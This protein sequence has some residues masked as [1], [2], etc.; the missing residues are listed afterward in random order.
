MNYVDALFFLFLVP[1]ILISG[2][3]RKHIVIKEWIIIFSS[4]LFLSTWGHR[5][6]FTFLFV[7]AMN[8]AAARAIN[9]TSKKIS[10]YVLASTITFNIGSLAYFKYYNFFSDIL[11]GTVIIHIA[12]NDVALPLAMSFYIF[13][14]ISYLVDLQAGRTRFG[15]LREYLFYLSFFPHLVAGPIVRSWQLFPQIGKC[16]NIPADV[17]IG[18]Y[19]L[20]SGLFLK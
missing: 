6:L 17:P 9:R 2:L 19:Q 3:L 5:S 20:T 4:L 15:N 16:R 7:I 12:Y 11:N 14:L 13:H 8:Y 1:L 18:L 10:R